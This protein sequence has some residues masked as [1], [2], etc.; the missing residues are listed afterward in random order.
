MNK[1]K[2]FICYHMELILLITFILALFAAIMTI[3]NRHAIN[4]DWDYFYNLCSDIL[5]LLDDMI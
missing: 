3:C 1:I 2:E 5:H 4:A